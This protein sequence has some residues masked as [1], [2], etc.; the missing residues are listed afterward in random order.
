MSGKREQRWW[1]L[2]PVA[3]R[4]GIAA[5]CGSATAAALGLTGVFAAEQTARRSGSAPARAADRVEIQLLGVN[6]FHGHLESPVARPRTPAGGKIALGGA[7]NLDAHLDRAQAAAPGKTIRVHAGDMLGASPLLSSHFHDEPSVRAMN[8]MDFDVGTLGNHEFDEGGDELLRMLEGGHR[9]DGRQFKP[10]GS[11]ERIDTSA[12]DFAGIDFP[13]VAANT[14]DTRGEL[15]LAPY[16]I[17][18]RAGARIG[19]IGVTTPSA[20][21]FLLDRHA[22]RFRWLDISDAVNRRADEL[23][24]RGVKAIVVLAHSG[25]VETGAGPTS[26]RGEIVDEARQMSPA[27][28]VVIAGHTHSRLNTRLADGRGGDKLIVES[29]SYGVAFDRVRMTIDRP[30]GEVV[31]KSAQTP[32]TWADEV[33]PDNALTGLVAGYRKQLAG[34]DERVVGRAAVPLARE[35][36]GAKTGS[37]GTVVARAQRRLAGAEIAFVNEG[38]SRES[39]DAGPITYGELFEA[40]AYEHQVEAMEMS[41]SGVRRALE[42]QLER[43]VLL[44]VDGLTY[45]RKGDRVGAIRLPGEKPLVPRR[46]YRVA[47]N[48]LLA[49]HDELDAFRRFGRRP[50]EVGTDFEALV[51]EVERVGVVR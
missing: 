21:T 39:I 48:Q 37:L 41:G 29:N 35:R 51:R 20:P 11:G 34:L 6:D 7:A 18:E 13:Y 50:R 4:A 31:A 42:Q 24:R 38:N 5:L 46:T 30:S 47:V 49:G 36:V 33:S 10:A 14:V 8:L 44:H 1:Q 22:R 2:S 43:G 15:D 26:A 17:V 25:A 32:S 9:E 23:Q 16:R 27:V 45:E 28:D 3:R 19:F 12:P 40:S